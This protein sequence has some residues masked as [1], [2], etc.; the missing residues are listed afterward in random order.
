[1]SLRTLCLGAALLSCVAPVAKAATSRARKTSRSRPQAIPAVVLPPG[2]SERDLVIGESCRRALE[3]VTGSVVALDPRTGR[4][5]ALVNPRYG[6]FNAYQPCSVFK[7]V[8]AIAGLSEGIITPETTWN[9]TT[10]CNVW[11]GHG[12]I[13]LRRAL[14]VSCNT[15]FEHVGE[16]LGYPTVE[17]YAHLLGLGA[18]SGINLTGEA[19]GRLPRSVGAS[20][21]GHLSSHAAGIATSAVQL[22]VLLSATVNGGVVYQPQVGPADRIVPR[23]RWRLPPGTVLTGLADG[24]VSAV[25]EG[26]ATPAFDP[27]IVVAGKT[28]SCSRLGWFAS[29]AP[30]ENP[31]VVIV[32][33]VRR[34]N[35]HKAS[36]IAGRIYQDIFKTDPP[37]GVGGLVAGGGS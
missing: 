14:A 27:D 19:Q 3:D 5:I 22:A 7:I 10:G 1:M 28:G 12:R 35:G 13:D 33:F 34:G 32:V 18:A 30:A 9:C 20:A 21:V 23:E 36:A 26:S 15:Y 17:K 24:F 25:N 6:L 29:Y 31:E 16:E 4:V 8:V 37:G 11:P 2:A